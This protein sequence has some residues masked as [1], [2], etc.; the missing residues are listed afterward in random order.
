MSAAVVLVLACAGLIA[1]GV[2][3]TIGLG[4]RGGRR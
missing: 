4:S 3:L 2:L 1:A